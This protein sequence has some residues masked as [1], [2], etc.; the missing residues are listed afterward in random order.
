MTILVTGAAGFI[1]SNL[2]KLLS[3]NDFQ[4]KAVDCFLNESYDANIKRK[5]WQ[6]LLSLP[7][8][9][10]IELDLRHSIPI[11]LLKN[12]K[13]I[14]NLAAMPGLMKSWSDF[15]VY[16]SCN[17][18][19]VENLAREATNIGKVHFIQISTSSV[20]GLHADGSEDSKLHPVSPY[21]VTKLASEELIKTY[22][23]TFGLDFTILRYFSVYGPG[24]RPDM[25]FNKIIKAILNDVEVEIYGDGT[26]TRTNTFI[27]D[28]VNATLSTILLLPKNEI[29]NVSGESYYSLNQGIA[30]IEEILNKKAKL[31]FKEKRPGDQIQTRG[32]IAKAKLLLNYKPKVDLFDGLRQQ[33]IWQRRI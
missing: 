30:I 29:I 4:I 12:V 25:A 13:V 1:G 3:K 9:E 17:I 27:S 18:E 21:G 15:R 2:V 20:Y 33:I 10:F 8:V 6:T 7:N 24:Q 32:N 16:S 11:D 28:C 22:N 26:Q 31:I 5:N 19:V 23:R 14:V